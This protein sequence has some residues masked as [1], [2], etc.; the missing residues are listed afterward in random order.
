MVKATLVY[1]PGSPGLTLLG[2]LH[3]QLMVASVTTNTNVADRPFVIE[4]E[5]R[6]TS[7][8]LDHI[9]PD[10]VRKVIIEVYGEENILQLDVA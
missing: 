6:P 8:P 1:R 10:F 9:D 7:G 5:V 2:E 4:L 3:R